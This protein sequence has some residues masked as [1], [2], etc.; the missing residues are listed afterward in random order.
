MGL[1]FCC[2][3]L[4]FFALACHGFV[5]FGVLSM[6]GNEFYHMISPSL[7][8]SSRTELSSAAKYGRKNMRAQKKFSRPGI[9]PAKSQSRTRCTRY[10]MEHFSIGWMAPGQWQYYISRKKFLRHARYQTHSCPPVCHVTLTIC[11]ARLL[12]E[13]TPPPPPPPRYHA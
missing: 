7:E 2:K 1:F 9:E 12:M 6:F 5:S 11:H 10:T 13:S 3:N 8:P 4:C